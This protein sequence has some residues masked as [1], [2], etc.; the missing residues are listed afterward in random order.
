MENDMEV[1]Q[2]IKTEAPYD[3]AILLLDTYPKETKTIT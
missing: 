1:P 2:K 3:P